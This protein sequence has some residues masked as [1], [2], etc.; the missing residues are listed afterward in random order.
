MLE[1]ELWVYK[2]TGEG[3]STCKVTTWAVCSLF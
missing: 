3:H 2:T 1:F